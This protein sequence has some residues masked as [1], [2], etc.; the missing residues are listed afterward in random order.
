MEALRLLRARRWTPLGGYLLFIGMMATGYYY[1]VTFV[2][3]GLVDL[4]LHVLGMNEQQVAT[5]MA[6]LALFTCLIALGMGLLMSRRP[7]GQSF[8]VKLR[9]AFLVVLVQTLLTAA[10]PFVP[11]EIFFRLWIVV[12][13]V[14]LGVGVPVTFS[15][16]VDLIPM[17]DRGYVAAA[18]TA[19]AYL[20]APVLSGDWR[21]ETFSTQ[22]LWIMLPGVLAIGL[23]AF[24][25]LPL[26]NLDEL[27]RQHTDPAFARGRFVRTP[28]K[29]LL[30]IDRRLAGFVLLMFGIYFVDSLGFLRLIE[31]PLYIETAWQSPEMNTRLAIGLVHVLGAWIAGVL[32]FSLDE[33]ALFYWTFGLFALVH[34]MYGMDIRLPGTGSAS[35][36]M[37]LLYSIAVSLYT[38]LN[39]AL[40]ADLSTP[41]TI[42]LYSAL[43]VGFAGWAATF[44]STA[45]SIQ[46]RIDGMPLAQHLNIVDALAM[47]FFIGLLALA[48]L[49]VGDR[50]R[51][52]PV[53]K[54]RNL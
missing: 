42:P 40:W 8:V 47:L 39:F 11:N 18:I 2:Q 7:W 33:K 48:V 29:P 36:S 20:A 28:S 1:N 46:W 14:A 32:Y 27:A 24:V 13:S 21:I 10:A 16:T 41:A 44:I 3:L 12:A 37:P 9:L 30:G 34:F 22:M 5:N 35:L 51:R 6:L 19:L 4:G 43:G 54:V 45:L 49:Q 17:R 15:M 50:P 25:K 31:T 53:Q 52:H 26:I 23:L 38:V